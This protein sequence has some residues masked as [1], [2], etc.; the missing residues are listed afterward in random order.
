MAPA[1]LLR[2]WTLRSVD[3]LRALR[4]GLRAEVGDGSLF[5]RMAVVGTELATNALIHGR[6]PVEVRLVAEPGCLVLNV[7]DHDLI[8]EPQ[9]GPRRPPGGGGLGLRLVRIFS[10]DHGW[11]RTDR[12]K[13]VWARFDRPA[14]R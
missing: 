1:V 10:T 4:A 7:A 3:E 2:Q 12:T 8:G 13:H 6:P 5:E 11:Y 9:V 14:S